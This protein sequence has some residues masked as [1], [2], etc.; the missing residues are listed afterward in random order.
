MIT[1][2]Y[3]D[4]LVAIAVLG[5]FTLT[6][7]QEFEEFVLAQVKFDR[8]VGLLEREAEAT[9]WV[10]FLNAEM[11]VFADSAEARAWLAEKP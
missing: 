9:A 1:T 3:R 7:F 8:P 6:D 5:E 4:S 10:L 11:R 2:D